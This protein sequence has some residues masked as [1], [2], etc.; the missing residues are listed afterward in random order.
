METV[1][2]YICRKSDNDSSVSLND[3]M[4]HFNNVFQVICECDKLEYL[5]NIEKIT[6]HDNKISYKA[7]K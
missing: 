6:S 1:Y 4:N 2:E 3:I 5:G 7:K